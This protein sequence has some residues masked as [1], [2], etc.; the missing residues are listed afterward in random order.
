MIA[1]VRV[2]KQ[3]NL[4]FTSVHK[5]LSL[6]LLS[7]ALT[8]VVSENQSPGI[9]GINH[10]SNAKANSIGVNPNAD[11]TYKKMDKVQNMEKEILELKMMFQAKGQE[12]DKEMEK[13]QTK[14]DGM[15]KEIDKLKDT[16]SSQS[17]MIDD[18][19]NSK[20]ED[21]NKLKA[22]IHQQEGVIEILK[23]ETE[24]LVNTVSDMEITI[25]ELEEYSQG[26]PSTEIADIVGT[27]NETKLHDNKN[28]P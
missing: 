20:T 18:L 19:K 14:M 28:I 17:E 6:I 21:E 11:N 13:M 8:L 5:M 2:T 3:A 15:G 27:A 26:K 7:F 22:K 9:S 10:R 1:D 12:M 25:N 16:V 4:I 23:Q 24:L